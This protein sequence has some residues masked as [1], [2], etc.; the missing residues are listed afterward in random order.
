MGVF[1][2]TFSLIILFIIST[3]TYANLS[4]VKSSSTFD[5]IL[6]L[7]ICTEESERLCP[8]FNLTKKDALSQVYTLCGNQWETLE[9]IWKDRKIVDFICK[10]D[11]QQANCKALGYDCFREN[12]CVRDWTVKSNVDTTS[13]DYIKALNDILNNPYHIYRYPQYYYLCTKNM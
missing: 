5:K 1:I 7:Y 12:Q 9:P 11:Q 8:Y 3:S 2:K 13:D 4:L 6:H 10:Y